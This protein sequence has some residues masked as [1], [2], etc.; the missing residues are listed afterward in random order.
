MKKGIYLIS[1]SVLAT[2]LWQAQPLAQSLLGETIYVQ[3]TEQESQVTRLADLRASG[4]QGQIYTVSGKV[5][6][7]VNAWGGNG[8]YIQDASG[9]GFYIYPNKD[10]LG[11]NEG[12]FVQLTGTLSNFNGEL[13]LIAITE[14][15]LIE[16]SH[17]TAITETTI[18]GL[19]PELQSTLVNLKDLTVGAI[20]SDRFKNAT[21][22][23]TDASGQ[24]L[25]VRLDSRSGV[26]AEAL[27]GKIGTGDKI[28]LTGVLST[29]QGNN[30]LKPFSLE[31]F[32]VVEKAG[33]SAVEPAAESLKIS[34]IQ[35]A[36]H[37]STY[38][39]KPVTVKDVVVTYIDTSNRFFVQDLVPDDD[40]R[41]S[42]GINVYLPKHG[43]AVGDVLTITGTVEEYFG[44][45]YAEKETTDLTITQI[46]ASQIEKTATA[47]VPA[48]VVLGVDRLIPDG[49]IDND[50]LTSFDPQED[51][52]DFWESLEGMLVAVDDAKIL[53]PSKYKELYV[54]P[55]S[56]TE[57]LNGSHGITLRPDKENTGII[58]VLLK[59]DFVAKAGD[60]FTG[61]LAG[62]VSYSYTNYKVLV[63]NDSLPQFN[64]GGL[65]PEKT[66]LV[67]DENKLSIASYNV[68]NFTADPGQTSEAKVTRI[69]KSFVEDLNGPD[70]I[71]LVEV[72]D[73]NGATDDGVV[74]ASQSAARLIAAIQALGGPKYTYVD[75]APENNADGGQPG[76][77]IRVGFLYNEARVQLAA[78]PVAAPNEAIS[79]T[80]GSLTHSVGRIAPTD[81]GFVG[82]RKSLAAEFLFKGEKVVVVANHLSSKRGDNGLYGR[83]QP[84]VMA[85]EGP[86]HQ[87]ALVLNQFAQAGIAQNPN[88]NIVMLGDFNDFEFRKTLQLIEGNILSNMVSRHDEADRFSYF[89]QGNNQSLDHILVSNNLLE[90]AEFDMIHVNSPFMEEHGRASDHDP[91]LLQL[92]LEP[93]EQP[94]PQETTQAQTTQTSVTTPAE[95]TVTEPTTTTSPAVTSGA[96]TSVKKPTG[97]STGTPTQP[98]TTVTSE[99]KGSETAPQTDAREGQESRDGQGTS[100]RGSKRILPKAGSVQGKGMILGVAL[101]SILAIVTFGYQKKQK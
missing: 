93:K 62:P 88:A 17:E 34:Q 90:R 87:Q 81:P 36:G 59:K 32:E 18:T 40:I 23:V 49:I 98:T 41:T 45:G 2:A 69:A 54:L 37:E 31:Q 70:I 53:G 24:T 57:Q 100:N 10:V 85:S 51:A 91:L 38:A 5:I 25:A 99:T 4:V 16:A 66:T 39:N 89:Y 35:G 95:T 21:F 72:Q 78:K 83:V 8:F 6:S 47:E 43:V 92:R 84:P 12:D 19:V 67:K 33:D 7:A 63:N 52:I 64:D 86:R 60:S 22:T 74:D 9:A 26:N 50:G 46:K 15:S 58:P 80:N 42:D 20:S 1:A 44:S 28:N 11:Y 65:Q 94:K 29:Y 96:Q 56:S 71:G 55:G 30:Q 73:N 75:I 77:N 48:P 13:Q 97:Q 82:V 68:E 14:H 61:R 27:M 76:A 79:W 3:A 101:L